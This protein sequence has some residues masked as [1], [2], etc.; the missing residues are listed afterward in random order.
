MLT[1]RFA[2][3]TYAG[4][5]VFCLFEYTIIPAIFHY[6]NEPTFEVRRLSGLLSRFIKKQPASELIYMLLRAL[7]LQLFP[8]ARSFS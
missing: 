6:K 8:K 1:D 2:F 5:V 3:P 4:S 7:R